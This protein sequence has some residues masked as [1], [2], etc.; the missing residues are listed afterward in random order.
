MVLRKSKKDIFQIWKSKKDCL[1]II[2]FSIIGIVLG[3]Q[4][5]YFMTIKH[6]NA[7]TCNY[8]SITIRT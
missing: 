4:Y 6:G 8:T 5:T 1:H 7:A 2:C 3:V